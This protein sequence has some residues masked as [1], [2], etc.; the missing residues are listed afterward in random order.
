MRPSKS[1]MLF[2]AMFLICLVPSCARQSRSQQVA[3]LLQY[4]NLAD[5]FY[6]CILN[7]LAQHLPLKQ[8][9]DECEIKLLFEGRKG[10][11][12]GVE[13]TPPTGGLPGTRDPSNY[14]PATVSAK[15]SAGDPGIAGKPS[16]LGSGSIEWESATGI[17]GR[18]SYTFGGKGES[19]G[20]GT[21]SN[22]EVG[23][24]KYKGLT[25]AE[26]RAE[27]QA[28]IDAF[29]AASQAFV[30]LVKKQTEQ[31]LK[32][33]KRAD[34]WEKDPVMKKE[35]DD[36]QKKWIDAKDKAVEDPNEDLEGITR[37]ASSSECEAALQAAR[38]I[39]GECQ[40]AGW[41]TGPC[42]ELK[43]KLEGCDT[44]LIYV[45]PGG[46]ACRPEIDPQALRNAWVER[47]R[48]LKRPVPGG[49]DP[50]EP[51]KFD[52]R[53]AQ[54]DP[55][56]ICGGPEVYVTPDNPDPRCVKQLVLPSSLPGSN[57]V[58]TTYV[59]FLNTFGG[60]IV[61]IG[62][63]PEPRPGP[64]PEPRPGPSSPNTLLR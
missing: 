50:C 59:W 53:F 23:I 3:K 5:S 30:E 12:V 2:C 61:V 63:R 46:Y 42:Q 52:G 62:P 34:D 37:T 11:V 40:L 47:C 25:E 10:T 57:K 24:I 17:K 18:E 6:A 21:N 8:I 29:K 51:P 54:G 32:E 33:G 55:Q 60:P 9:Q 48:E 14:D 45:E 7:G 56:Q 64:G 36:A 19:N 22:G 31:L 15:C 58:Q 13:R 20:Y 26:A 41:R 4:P 43:G 27:K 49:P 38:E 28:A 39:V 1:L 44:T 16:T 35:R